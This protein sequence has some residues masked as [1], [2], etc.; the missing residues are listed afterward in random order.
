MKNLMGLL[1]EVKSY[2]SPVV[3]Y[4]V[5]LP[6]MPSNKRHGWCGGGLCPFHD[7]CH[8]GSF[9][10]NLTTGPFHCFTCGTSGTDIV[11]FTR[12]KYGLSF[13]V[14]LQKLADEWGI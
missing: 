2:I 12:L 1:Q 7:D 6:A 11:A 3:F 4:L 10:V 9:K 14:T 13:P 8:P 5:E